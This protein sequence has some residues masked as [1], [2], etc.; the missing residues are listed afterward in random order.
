MSVAKK[1]V[2][3]T[4]RKLAIYT[5]EITASIILLILICLP[6]V[7]TVPMWIQR[8][9]FGTAPADLIVNPVSWF[10]YTGAFLIT[11]G[12]AIIS[13]ILGYPYIMR[14]LPGAE[15]AEFE[16]PTIDEVTEEMEETED[17]DE[18]EIPEA[19]DEDETADEI[20]DETETKFSDEDSDIDE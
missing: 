10:G 11:I 5:L 8:V 3:S 12:L 2:D 6:L 1:A 4:L 18:N 19:Y 7:F 14:L 20:I 9:A 16:K 15:K 13:L 17:I